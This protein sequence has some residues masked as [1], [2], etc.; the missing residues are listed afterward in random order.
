MKSKADAV[1]G[2][3]G[4]IGRKDTAF[5]PASDVRPVNEGDATLPSAA[6]RPAARAMESCRS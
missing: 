4:F 1:K 6:V 5:E 3:E 2:A